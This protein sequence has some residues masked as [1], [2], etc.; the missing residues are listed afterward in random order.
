MGPPLTP[1]K[2]FGHVRARTVLLGSA[3]SLNLPCPR[4]PGQP[5]GRRTP[6]G[7]PGAGGRT[8]GGGPDGRAAGNAYITDWFA[9]EIY[10]YI[11]TF[12]IYVY[13]YMYCLYTLNCL[14]WVYCLYCPCCLYCRLYVHV[15]PILP[16]WTKQ[17]GH[18]LYWIQVHQKPATPKHTTTNQER[19]P[20]KTQTKIHMGNRPF[21]TKTL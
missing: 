14:C 4:C 3:P 1:T 6:A 11:N 16:I 12:E 2:Q 8:A 7:R 18:C 19:H 21:Q 5:G 10:V 13:V 20:L 9:F 15:L 17:F